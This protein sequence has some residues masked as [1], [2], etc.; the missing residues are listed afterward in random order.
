MQ[1]AESEND[2]GWENGEGGFDINNWD[3]GF[4]FPFGM[5]RYAM[6]HLQLM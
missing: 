2:V 5:S 4:F 1:L 3:C 6:I